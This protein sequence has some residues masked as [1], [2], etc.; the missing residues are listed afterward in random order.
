MIKRRGRLSGRAGAVVASARGEVAHSAE[1]T[2]SRGATPG[3]LLQ[4]LLR[5]FADQAL[6]ELG[7]GG[8][9]AVGQLSDRPRNRAVPD[10]SNSVRHGDAGGCQSDGDRPSVAAGAPLRVS[11]GDKA[12]HQSHGSRVGQANDLTEGVN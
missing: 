12:I 2:A 8:A 4:S 10:G 7:E 11:G 9:L 3:A 6:A 5:E 1:S